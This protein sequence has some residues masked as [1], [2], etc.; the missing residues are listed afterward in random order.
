M[1]VFGILCSLLK[2]AVE[3][4]VEKER[5]EEW[6]RYQRKVA[7]LEKGNEKKEEVRIKMTINKK[8]YIVLKVR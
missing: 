8:I 5:K 1:L 6:P 4:V 3:M 2:S 7:K